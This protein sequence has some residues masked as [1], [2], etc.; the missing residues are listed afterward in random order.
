MLSLLTVIRN[1]DYLKNCPQSCS[2]FSTNK[3]EARVVVATETDLLVM[4]THTSSSDMDT[5]VHV[6]EIF[7]NCIVL[8]N[9]AISCW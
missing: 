4:L 2:H 7:S 6:V 8:V 5:H 3:E 1:P 9:I